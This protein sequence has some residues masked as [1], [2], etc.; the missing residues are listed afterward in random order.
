[1][2]PIL[3]ILPTRRAFLATAS[4]AG[5]AAA[6]GAST[7]AAADKPRKRILVFTKC[8]NYI[9]D[10][11]KGGDGSQSVVGKVLSELAAQE[12][13]ELV[14][15][16]D[17]SLFNAAYLDGFD[18][19]FFFTSGDL[20]AEG[21]DK[22]PPMSAEGKA[23]FLD[24][25]R[26]GKG[27]IGSHSAADTFHTGEDV[28]T[29]TKIR[30]QRYKNYGEAADPYTRMLGAGFIIHGKQQDTTCEVIDP[31]FPGFAGYGKS[32]HRVEEWY[33][34]NDFS[35][36]LHV[37][38]VMETQGLKGNM[39]QRPP[40]PNTWARMH[41]KGR[42]FFTALAHNPETWADANFQQMVSGAFAWSTGRVDAEI[43]PNISQVTP[44]AWDLP[45]QGS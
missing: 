43:T 13:Y 36:D 19:Y 2:N 8:S 5:L 32:F 24:A 7:L 27:F 17:G 26:K 33:S 1:M 38:L 31:S 6:F 39:Y 44:G 22:N 12:N 10:V 34:L 30:T 9:H 3:P 14:F 20:L 35:K 15:S 37:L 23:A 42:V 16:K 28:H 21:N 29:D 40:Y 45:P 4:M 25:I 18:A 11:V 41:G